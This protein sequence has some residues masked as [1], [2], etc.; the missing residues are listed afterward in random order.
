MD[1]A[2][3]VRQRAAA[4][5]LA[6]VAIWLARARMIGTLDEALRQAEASNTPTRVV[7]GIKAASA[8]AKLSSDLAGDWRATTAAFLASLRD[9]GIVDALLASG[10]NVPWISRAIG[11]TA[12][13]GGSVAEGGGKTV[14]ELVADPASLVQ[15]KAATIVVMSADLFRE[16]G[17]NGINA[18]ND[19]LRRGVVAAGDSQ[20]LTVLLNGVTPT[21]SVGSIVADVSQ[22]LS[23]L[24][25][26]A[27][28]RIVFAVGANV[29]D[30]LEA[31]PADALPDAL[32]IRP[33]IRS[34]QVDADSIV[35]INASSVVMSDGGLQL[36][37]AHH[38]SLQ[39]D[40]TPTQEA[41]AD[42]TPN[43]T[44]VVSMWQTDSIA[45][46]AERTFKI[47]LGR[48]GAVARVSGVDWV[49]AFLP[50]GETSP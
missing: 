24:S 3:A 6:Q 33:V 20:A 28:S 29:R 17:P 4:F 1:A 9:V 48:A 39:M 8:G 15:R 30:Q 16:A 41:G 40:D 36:D 46:R 21:P 27:L 44:N 43:P 5:E 11:L 47:A 10:I 42:G 14:R 2:D 34:D 13:A 7:S 23:S 37:V 32:R 50:P 26:D 18:V 35:A 22:L 25:R 38:A 19:E 49:S 12:I 45:L 31:M